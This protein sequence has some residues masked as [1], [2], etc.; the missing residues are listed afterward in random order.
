MELF[1]KGRVDIHDHDSSAIKNPSLSRS[2]PKRIETKDFVSAEEENSSSA[3]ETTNFDDLDTFKKLGL[4][5]F[6]CNCARNLGYRYPTP[7]QQACIPAILNGRD[8]IGCA[9]T[10]SGKV[11]YR[12]H[13]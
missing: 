1:A 2:N 3:I 11:T 10:G 8:V 6:L 13:Y 4:S 9:E 7:I 12:S 5:D